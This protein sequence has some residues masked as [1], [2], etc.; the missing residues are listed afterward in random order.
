[1]SSVKKIILDTN[2]VLIPAQYGVDIFEEI[3]AT[4]QGQAELYLLD[5]SLLELEKIAREQKGALKR[6]VKLTIDLIKAKNIKILPTNSKEGAKTVDELLKEYA[7]EGYYIATQD[8]AVKQAIK[9][10]VIFLRQMKRI[11]IQE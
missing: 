5:K 4:L 1:M 2:F 8:K 10:R 6:Q 11:E 9:N 3:N 7:Q